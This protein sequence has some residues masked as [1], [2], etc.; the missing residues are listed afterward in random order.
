MEIKI[1]V[2]SLG[3]YN[4]G[5]LTGQWTKL[6][7]DDIKKEII[8]KI[9]GSIGDEFFITDYEAPFKIYKYANIYDV[10]KLAQALEEFETIED[11]YWDLDDRDVISVPEIY[12]FDDEFFNTMFSC[13]AEAVRAAFFGNIQN[14]R[15]EYIYFDGYG[16]LQSITERQYKED[17]ENAADEIIKEF[18]DENSL[19]QV[20]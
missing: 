12:T 5:V 15:D 2:S 17:I 8:D 19:A 11:V 6:P 4:S 1:W 20:N 9:E 3:A 14:W 10:N 18:A 16:N 13:P 7:V